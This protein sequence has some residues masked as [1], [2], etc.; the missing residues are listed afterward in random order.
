MEALPLGA[1]LL[2]ADHSVFRA[3]GWYLLLRAFVARF[4]PLC[5]WAVDLRLFC[6]LFDYFLN[7]SLLLSSC[8][9]SHC[10][11][12]ASI[13]IKLRHPAVTLSV[14]VVS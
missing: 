12:Y 8:S 2:S 1:C 5:L 14:R 6:C 7:D 10:L 4:V 9:I 13:S 3:A 11:A